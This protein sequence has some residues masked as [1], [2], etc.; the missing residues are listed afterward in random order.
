M[1]RVGS[2]DGVLATESFHRALERAG[3]RDLVVELLDTLL[4]AYPAA[5]DVA[6]A[7]PFAD[8]ISDTLVIVD[9]IRATTL[10]PRGVESKSV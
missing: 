1:A 2:A 7:D 8:L 10:T 5:R 9:A 4:V 6:G 3:R